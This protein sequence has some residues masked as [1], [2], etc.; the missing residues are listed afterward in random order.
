MGTYDTLVDGDKSAQIKMFDCDLTT[1][2]AGDKLP[3]DKTFTII[4]PSFCWNRF[5]IVKDGIFIKLTNEES[6]IF[7]PYVDKWGEEL[8]SSHI[9]LDPT[10]ELINEII[11]TGDII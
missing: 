1:Y 8:V 11:K 10:R 7:S 9:L 4:F 6:E 3:T 5:A 2:N